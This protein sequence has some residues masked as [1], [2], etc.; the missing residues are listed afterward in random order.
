MFMRASKRAPRPSYA[1]VGKHGNTRSHVPCPAARAGVAVPRL[2][3]MKPV[4]PRKI[5]SPLCNSSSSSQKAQ[6][7]REEIPGFSWRC[8]KNNSNAR[9]LKN[10]R[11]FASKTRKPL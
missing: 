3:L 6:E 9:H 10:R 11:F 5:E 8:A 1:G 2:D 7:T 4:I